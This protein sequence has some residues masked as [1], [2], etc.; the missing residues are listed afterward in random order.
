MSSFGPYFRGLVGFWSLLVERLSVASVPGAAKGYTTKR[1]FNG[2]LKN[3]LSVIKVVILWIYHRG[4]ANSGKLLTTRKTMHQCV[5]GTIYNR[6][7]SLEDTN[8]V[9]RKRVFKRI[10]KKDFN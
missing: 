2:L 3:T 1:N 9:L 8:E 7:T 5:L 10:E 6:S 4:T